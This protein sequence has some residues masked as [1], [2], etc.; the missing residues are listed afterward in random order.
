M[1]NGCLHTYF[2]QNK[3]HPICTMT[4]S[5]RSFQLSFD[6]SCCRKPNC[7]IRN[8]YGLPVVSPTRSPSPKLSIFSYNRAQRF[9][10]FRQKSLRDASKTSDDKQV[11]LDSAPHAIRSATTDVNE[12]VSRGVRTFRVI[13]SMTSTT[14]D[15]TNDWQHKRTKKR[16]HQKVIQPLLTISLPPKRNIWKPPYSTS[17]Y[18]VFPLS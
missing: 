12:T 5:W 3:N 7:H 1:Q 11:F 18:H 6:R 10:F 13:Q 17:S 16:Q 14:I 8:D 4:A 2:A 15:L 9:S